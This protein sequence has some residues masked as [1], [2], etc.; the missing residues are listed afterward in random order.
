MQ[1]HITFQLGLSILA[2]IAY[3]VTISFTNGLIN[4]Y[5]AR[6]NFLKKRI[7]YLKKTVAGALFIFYLIILSLVWG[8]NFREVLIFASSLFAV[9]GIAFFASWSILSNITTGIIIFSS[10]PYQIG[11]QIRILDGDN[12]VTGKII[13]MTLFHIQIK[14]ENGDITA[15]PNNLIIQRPVVK[16]TNQAAQ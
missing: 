16:L 2:T 15:Y 6:Q 11:D 14:N 8:V 13:D 1:M 5:G 7:L 4:K 9:A 12:S 3:L 10:F